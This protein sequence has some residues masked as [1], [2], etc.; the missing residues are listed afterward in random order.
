MR[1]YTLPGRK[2]RGTYALEVAVKSFD[3]YTEWYGIKQPLPKCDLI[4]I[5]QFAMGEFELFYI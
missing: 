5:P 3:Y 1:V 2:E 4:A